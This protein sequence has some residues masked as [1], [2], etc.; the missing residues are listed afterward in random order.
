MDSG[1]LTKTALREWEE[2]HEKEL[3][4]KVKEEDSEKARIRAAAAEQ[5]AKWEAERQA[6]IEKTKK[7]NRMEEQVGLQA[8][9]DS[10]DKVNSTDGISWERVYQLIDFNREPTPGQRDTS[11]MK[12]LL[13][14]MRQSQ[15]AAS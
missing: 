12:Q 15:Q 11:R 13:F 6:K 14:Q 5:R 9:Q 4:M 2:R 7:A 3:E 10:F 8:A 1:D